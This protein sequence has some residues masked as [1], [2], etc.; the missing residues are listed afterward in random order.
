MKPSRDGGP[1]PFE[2]SCG[3]CI[4]RKA[5]PRTPAMGEPEQRLHVVVLGCE[6]ELNR[7]LPVS[8]M[9]NRLEKR[10]GKMLDPKR[11]S[12]AGCLEGRSLGSARRGSRGD[13]ASADILRKAVKDLRKIC[14]DSRNRGPV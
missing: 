5:D 1:P 3:L 13:L 11:V 9:G 10:A 8:K 4:Y 12:V 2:A 14:I 7:S 6:A